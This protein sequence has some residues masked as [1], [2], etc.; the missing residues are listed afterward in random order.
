MWLADCQELLS[1]IAKDRQTQLD[2]NPS[3]EPGIEPRTSQPIGQDQH[4]SFTIQTF[5]DLSLIAAS[6]LGSLGVNQANT[7]KSYRLNCCWMRYII[8]LAVRLT[9]NQWNNWMWQIYT[10]QLSQHNS[11]LS[12]DWLCAWNKGLCSNKWELCSWKK[13]VYTWNMDLYSL[14]Y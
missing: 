2:R 3:L 14:K 4:C 1:K 6:E 8:L 10:L 13:K 7:Q 12:S 9:C 11:A 5:R